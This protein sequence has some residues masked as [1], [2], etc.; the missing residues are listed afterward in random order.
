[1]RVLITGISGF[2]GAHLAAHLLEAGHDVA[3]LDRTGGAPALEQL[4]RRFPERFPR[5]AVMAADVRDG[6]RIHQVVR[7]LRPDGVVH[8]A[9]IAFVPRAAEDPSAAWEVNLFGSLRVLEAVCDESPAARVVLVSSGEV[10]GR[11][12]PGDLPIDEAQALRPLA[13]YSAAKAA[14]DLAAYQ[15]FWSRDLA[16]VRARPFNHTGPGQSPDFVCSHFARAIAAAE[17]RKGPARL[18][19]GNLDVARDFSDV[20]DV[21]RGYAA[22]LEGGAAGEAYNLGSGRSTSVRSILDRLLE[23][24]R[25]PITVDAEAARM[26]RKEIP[27]IEASIARIRAATGWNPEIDL[28]RTLDDLLEHWRRALA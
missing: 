26:R 5:E 28:D 25:V 17:L 11:V 20:R 18:G 10:Y 4:H 16:V 24:S 9:G 7:A 23:R 22:L 8:L 21:V 3:G 27:R 13:P 6:A 14:A 12:E 19:V 2:A 15:F 1:M